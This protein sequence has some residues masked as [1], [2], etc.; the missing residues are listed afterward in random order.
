MNAL[1]VVGAFEVLA[2]RSASVMGEM[3]EM[4]FGGSA[5]ERFETENL[6]MAE[7]ALRVLAVA[8]KT[9]PADKSEVNEED[10]RGLTFLGLVGM[11]DPPRAAVAPAIAKCKKAGVRVI[12]LTGDQKAT[13]MAVG[14][15]IG[16]LPSDGSSVQ[17]KVFMERDVAGLSD[18]AFGE[19]L[20]EAAVFARVTPQTKLRIVTLLQAA[21]HTVAMT[22]DGVNDAPALKKAS[23]GVAMG[24]T[25][26]D[27]S[28]EV[29]DMVLADDNFVSIVSAIEEGRLVFRNVKQ[30]TAYLFMTNVGEVV[31][32]LASLALGLPLPI[33]PA[34]I[35][36]MN[37][38]TDGFPDVALATE[39]VH[40]RVLDEP[41]RRKDTP[42]LS[43]NLYLLT[44]LTSVVMCVGTLFLFASAMKTGDMAYART[45]AFTAMAVFQLW[46]VFS[47]RS[48]TQSVFRIGFFSNAY[49]VLA[50]AASLALQFAVLYVPQLQKI[51]G[52]QPLSVLDWLRIMAVT[53]T[54]FVAVEAYKVFCRRGFIPK[55]WY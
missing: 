10:L 20:K 42:I 39:G 17:G 27:V 40:G 29:A 22:G 23:I 6:R 45:V 1:F 25:G 46:N 33:L 24:I 48:G 7:G 30:T 37:L 15:E 43:Y 18:E 12:M 36:W 41:P 19:V 21:G 11:I 9:F 55:S 14:R 13:A 5:R 49:V 28:K 44:A 26:T 31:T 35:L 8:M 2:E 54:V 34:Q 4:P 53:G 16:L 32:V 51:F 47:M 38:V 52:T 50:V 3:A